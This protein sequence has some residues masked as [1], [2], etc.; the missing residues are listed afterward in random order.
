[1]FE[2]VEKTENVLFD[3]AGLWLDYASIG[4]KYQFKREKSLFYR[5]ITF[6]CRFQKVYSMSDFPFENQKRVL[7]Y[8]LFCQCLANWK[9]TYNA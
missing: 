6:D 3:S 4:F 1:M 2:N 7:L 5:I 9:L 8:C